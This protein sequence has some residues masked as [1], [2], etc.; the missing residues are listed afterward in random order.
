MENDQVAGQPE[1]VYPLSETELV[2]ALSSAIGTNISLVID[3][4]M[5]QLREF[6]YEPYLIKISKEILM[7][8]LYAERTSTPT[9]LANAM[10]DEGNDL[11]KDSKDG[12]ILASAAIDK[13]N[14]IRREKSANPRV[15]QQ[16]KKT[17]FIISSLKHPDEVGRLRE[18][19]GSVF[20]LVAV[21]E[22]RE[23]RLQ[24]LNKAKNLGHE[25]AVKLVDRDAGESDQMGQQT[26]RV[27]ELADIHMSLNPPTNDEAEAA[28][29]AEQ[30]QAKKKAY[31]KAQVT[32][33]LDLMFGNPFL[34]PT[35]DEY[36][37]F[38]AYASSLRSAD[39]GRQV[40]AAIVNQNEEIVATGAND[41]PR[42]G[43]GQY[44]PDPETFEDAV[45][46]RD[47]M[48][49]FDANKRE[50][51]RI[52]DE[53]LDLFEY[54][55][56]EE[57]LWKDTFRQKLLGSSIKYLT[58]YTR[59]VHAEMAAILACAR[60]GISLQGATL[61]CST[62]P[63]HNCAKHIVHA[64]LKRVVYIEPYP[65][66]KTLDLYEDSVTITK[67]GNRVR[68]DEFVGVGPRRF[69]DFFSLQ[70]S[71]GRCIM[72]KK[73]DEDGATGIADGGAAEWKRMSA[74][75]R[76]QTTALSY[77]EKETVESLKWAQAKGSIDQNEQQ[78][79]IDVNSIKEEQLDGGQNSKA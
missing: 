70:L 65:K 8:R 32:R 75:L 67:Q 14:N 62:F 10:M 56:P 35:I 47:Y 5:N 26:R 17:A 34:T 38:V 1:K 16:L 48:R 19:Y 29:D 52:I 39:L 28:K 9:L 22:T 55:T 25:D 60:N 79:K 42:F 71:S 58:E 15:P 18:T 74:R 30:K 13:I 59:A 41:V 53:I 27:F 7:P 68:F 78:N 12:A 2:I 57:T 63:C 72:R 66:S 77:I 40:G 44:W 45:N 21:N 64:G 20:F 23:S 61:Y 11:R 46:G 51:T 50:H 33:V 31:L 37:M 69:F 4:F 36:A 6:S 49:G 24:Y 3:E 43:G 76:F 73:E 54:K